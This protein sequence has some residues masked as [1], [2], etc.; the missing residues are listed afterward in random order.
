VVRALGGTGTLVSAL[1]LVEAAAFGAQV[2]ALVSEYMGTVGRLYLTAN[3]K[4]Q[5]I[6]KSVMTSGP[7]AATS[8]QPAR[9]EIREPA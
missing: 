7:V 9:Q 3:R 6:V 4:P 8:N 5:S 2:R 1:F